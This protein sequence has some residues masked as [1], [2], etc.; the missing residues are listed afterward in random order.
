MFVALV[1]SFHYLFD[2]CISMHQSTTPRHAWSHP[3]LPSLPE[4]EATTQSFAWIYYLVSEHLP[5]KWLVGNKPKVSV[6]LVQ[7]HFTPVKTLGFSSPTL[8][9]IFQKKP[10][11]IQYLYLQVSSQ[12]K[13]YWRKQC[14][15][16]FFHIYLS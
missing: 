12:F 6:D 3:T 9:L 4:Q 5:I 7:K 14:K 15:L 11:A 8:S 13:S 10:V 1:L 2:L 16:C